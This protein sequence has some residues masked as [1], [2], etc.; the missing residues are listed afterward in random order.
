MPKGDFSTEIRIYT[1]SRALLVELE[2]NPSAH[3]ELIRALPQIRTDVADRRERF[4]NQ[5]RERDR[6]IVDALLAVATAAL[7]AKHDAQE[8]TYRWWPPA[9]RRAEVDLAAAKA[10]LTE[11]VA[12]MQAMWPEPDTNQP[13]VRSRTD[14][15]TSAY[16]TSKESTNAR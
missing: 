12:Q 4:L 14:S 7:D 3:P 11:A 2:A 13:P 9:A 8:R 6:S 15:P 16:T 1:K 10:N 5:F